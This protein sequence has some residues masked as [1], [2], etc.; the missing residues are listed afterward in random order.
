MKLTKKILSSFIVVL[1]SIPVYADTFAPSPS[2]SKP[3]KPYQ[4]NTQ[5]E[6]DSFN[7]DVQLYKRCIND[8]V[9]EQNEAVNTHQDAAND[10]IDEWNRFVNYELN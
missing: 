1:F 10:A 7:D 3:I 8:F 4:F 5:W 9:E 6:I 2:C